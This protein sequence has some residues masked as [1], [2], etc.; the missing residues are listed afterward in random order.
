MPRPSPS[1]SR[2]P[3]YS[4]SEPAASES[5]RPDPGQPAR[6]LLGPLTRS[7]RS[8][9][10]GQPQAVSATPSLGNARITVYVVR[11]RESAMVL[12]P[13]M[14]SYAAVRLAPAAVMF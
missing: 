4:G 9:S 7:R 6:R 5:K 14:P 3:S 2:R 8:V 12:V 10:H 13:S 1:P 11:P